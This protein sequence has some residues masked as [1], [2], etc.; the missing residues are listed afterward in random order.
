M[1]SVLLILA[2]LVASS[3]GW[4]P[5]A[6]QH[7]AANS[8]FL[9]LT[10]YWDL[11]GLRSHSSWRSLLQVAGVRSPTPLQP[12]QHKDPKM[13]AVPYPETS[14]TAMGQQ[15]NLQTSG[16]A[17]QV[18]PFTHWITSFQHHPR[19]QS[20]FLLSRF[21]YQALQYYYYGFLKQQQFLQHFKGRQCIYNT[22]Q[23]DSIPFTD[24]PVQM[25]AHILVPY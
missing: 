12:E 7:P 5:G 20:A 17:N 21:F 22:I 25:D 3:S 23:D 8:R 9:S 2:Q 19:H 1:N 16:L 11:S 15:R 13:K 4:V 18:A 10:W 14:S 24:S 6:N